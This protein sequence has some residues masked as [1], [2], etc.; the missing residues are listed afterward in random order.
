MS[1]AA[2]MLER[3]DNVVFLHREGWTLFE[4]QTP[5]IEGWYVVAG[6]SDGGTWYGLFE[7]VEDSL[8]G[9]VNESNPWPLA[10]LRIPAPPLS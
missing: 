6:T 8:V 4:D 2:Q 9:E 1:N 5:E 7:L 10:Y 3:R